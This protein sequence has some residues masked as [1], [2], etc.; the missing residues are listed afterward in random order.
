MKDVIKK[1]TDSHLRS[2]AWSSGSWK[3]TPELFRR[4]R[5]V[6]GV[7]AAFLLVSGIFET[8]RCSRGL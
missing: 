8:D 6:C 4:I 7:F 1:S 5:Y 3:P 2:H